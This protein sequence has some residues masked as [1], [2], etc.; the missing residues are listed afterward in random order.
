MKVKELIERLRAIDPELTVCLGDWADDR[1]WPSESAVDE[2]DPV[3]GSDQPESPGRLVWVWTLGF[4]NPDCRVGALPASFVPEAAYEP[5]RRAIRV[6]WSFRLESDPDHGV[7]LV[8]VL[9]SPRLTAAQLIEACRS[10][11]PGFS[12]AEESPDD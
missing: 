10:G 4:L 3:N 2:P 11:E 9:P 5:T 8:G 1:N 7:V 6:P 12:F